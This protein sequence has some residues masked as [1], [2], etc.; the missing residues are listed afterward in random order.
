MSVRTTVTLDDDVV[1]RVRQESRSR[2]TSFRATL[3]ELLRQV[4][5]P[6]AP[7]LRPPF[8]VKPTSMGLRPGIDY[9]CIGDLIKYIDREESR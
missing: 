6:A 4:L 3:N 5:I 9:D 7:A 8:K 1:E 2:G